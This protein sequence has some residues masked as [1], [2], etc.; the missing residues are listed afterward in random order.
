MTDLGI[1]RDNPDYYATQVFNEAFGG[2][3]SSRLFKSI[4]TAQGLA[5]GVG[6]GMGSAFDHPG[7]VRISMSTKSASTVESIQALYKQ[8]DNLEKNPISDEEIKQAK[9]SILNSFVFN[10][11]SP[12]KVLRERMAYEFYG[13]PADYLERYRTGIEKVGKED[14]ARAAAKYLHKE[15]LAVLVVGNTAEFDK[16]LSSL[17]SVTNVDITIPPPPARKARRKKRLPN[18]L[19]PIQKAK[20]WLRRSSRPW[21]AW[22]SCSP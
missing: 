3:F 16:P 9:D 6:G 12:E 17:G 14:V 19:P 20:R 5:Y 8:I 21:A 11:D 1:R 13:Y 22:T 18:L 4:R 2:G 10:F 15:Q 7:I